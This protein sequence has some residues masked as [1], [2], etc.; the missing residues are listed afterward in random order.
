MGLDIGP[1]TTKQF[2]DVVLG[3]KTIVWNGPAGVF[4]WEN[5]AHGTKGIMDAAVQATAKGA[6][7]IIGLFYK[8]A[9]K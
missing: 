1:E 8:L 9:K 2:A 3:A 5:F 4:E 6:V 7:T